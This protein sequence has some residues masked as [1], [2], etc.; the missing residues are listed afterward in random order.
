MIAT[1]HPV[2]RPAMVLLVG[3]LLISLTPAHH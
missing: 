3:A 2:V 1:R